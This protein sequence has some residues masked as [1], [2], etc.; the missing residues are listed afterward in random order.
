MDGVGGK[1]GWAWLFILE[2]LF[3]VVF[4]VL[5]LFF[6]PHSIERASFLTP[7]E[8]EEVLAQLRHEGT[9]ND[10]GDTFSWVEVG[11]AFL[12]L[13]VWFLAAIFTFGGIILASLA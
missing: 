4:G 3:S 9:V 6:L 11:Q 13:Q 2:G 12:S 8:K 5:S 1:R 7:A 10:N